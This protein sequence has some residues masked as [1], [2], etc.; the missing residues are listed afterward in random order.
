MYEA[1]LMLVSLECKMEKVGTYTMLGGGE[2]CEGMKMQ[3]TAALMS[4]MTT[5]VPT[6]KRYA[7]ALRSEMIEIR[8][9]MICMRN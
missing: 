1:M 5:A 2:R 8:L 3:K 6:F 9:M 4:E 7:V